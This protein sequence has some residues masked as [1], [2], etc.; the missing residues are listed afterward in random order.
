MNRFEQPSELHQTLNPTLWDDGE[1]KQPVQIALLRIAKAYWKF[2][3]IDTRLD[4]VL[5]TGSQA[6]YNYSKH[7]DI[8]LHLVVDY[9]DVECD[10]AVDEL[11]KTKRDLWK[12]EHDIDIYGIPVEVYVEDLNR[13]AVSATYSIVKNMWIK[14]PQRMESKAEIDRIE[15]LCLA[16]MILITTRLATKELDQIR[17]VKD[18]L[19]SYR[20]QGLAIEG[21]MGVPNLVFKTLRNSG[22]T[23]MLLAAVRKLGDDDLSLEDQL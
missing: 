5:V 17:Q 11:F 3:G 19:W 20:K 22:V 8:D 21:E 4:D 14:P 6:N 9:N 13:P 12:A 23:D 2:L 1:L 15:R 10:M 7:S 16:W 18:M